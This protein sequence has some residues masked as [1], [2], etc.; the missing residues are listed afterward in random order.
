MSLQCQV[1]LNY[2]SYSVGQNAPPNATVT[3]YNPN[4]SAVV[5]MGIAITSRVLNGS[6]V[7]QSAMSQSLPPTG[8]GM[9]VL[10][11]TLSSITFGPFPITVGSAANANSFQAVNQTGNLNPIN[12]QVALPPQFTLLVGATVTGSDGSN[13][14]A[15][16]APLLVS[17]CPPPPLGWQGGFLQFS[18][19]NNLATG[20]LAG[21]L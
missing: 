11:P 3:V 9:T 8:P 14:V 18:A 12:P 7:N 6:S 13:N 1:T 5:V 10:V 4:A 2:S 17:Y 16:V 19:P 21:V 20:F 15:G